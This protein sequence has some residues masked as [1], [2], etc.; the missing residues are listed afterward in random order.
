MQYPMYRAHIRSVTANSVKLTHDK[1]LR[2]LE[3]QLRRLLCWH[4]EFL[5]DSP[6]S[7]ALE[8]SLFT[9]QVVQL[10]SEVALLFGDGF[11]GKHPSPCFLDMRGNVVLL[12]PN[13][14]QEHPQLLVPSR[15][16]IRE[17][18][19]MIAY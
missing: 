18:I 6:V 5:K 15:E 11:V 10:L 2:C 17:V 14:R 19:R 16:L 7:G 9:L 8:I 13:S 4:I 12:H 1:A 3:A